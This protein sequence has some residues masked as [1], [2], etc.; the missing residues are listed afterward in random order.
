M[1]PLASYMLFPLE[2][3]FTQK[4]KL[5]TPGAASSSL[6]RIPCMSSSLFATSYK[7]HN[8]YKFP[9]QNSPSANE[10]VVTWPFSSC[11]FDESEVHLL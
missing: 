4:Q 1:P 8:Y 2:L 11:C 9:S 5:A 3:Q 7:K 10:I 6:R